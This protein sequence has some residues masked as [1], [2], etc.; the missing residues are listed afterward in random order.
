MTTIEEMNAKTVEDSSWIIVRAIV[1]SVCKL[2]HVT[3]R[4]IVGMSR[5]ARL[6]E[7]RQ[8]AC[9]LARRNTRLS[10]RE[11]GE[12]MGFRDHTTVLHGV[13]VIDKARQNDLR[14]SE[15]IRILDAEIK[16]KFSTHGDESAA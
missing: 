13:R 14:V 6:V 7:A 10:Y 8:I 1:I 5:N 3:E 12:G 9:W 15:Y 16:A 4:E 11:I 2:L